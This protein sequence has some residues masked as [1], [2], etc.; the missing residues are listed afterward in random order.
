MPPFR[1][2]EIAWRVIS[3]AMLVPFG[4]AVGTDLR[5]DVS[6]VGAGHELPEEAVQLRPL[7]VAVPW[8][9]E[10]SYQAASGGDKTTT[11]TTTVSTTSASYN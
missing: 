2:T 8:E 11:T 6:G 3:G 10:R 5:A 1:C 9:R 7:D 4:T